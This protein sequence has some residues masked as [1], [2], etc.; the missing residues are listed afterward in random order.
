[1]I[2]GGCD[3]RKN[4]PEGICKIEKASDGLPIRC[5]GLWAKA[6]G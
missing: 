2:C 3:Y 5:V 1:M 4:A 6:S